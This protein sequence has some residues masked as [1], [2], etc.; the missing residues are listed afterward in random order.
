[1]INMYKARMKLLGQFI[2]V[3]L[4][5]FSFGNCYADEGTLE[6]NSVENLASTTSS[7]SEP[8]AAFNFENVRTA[9]VNKDIVKLSENVTYPFEVCENDYRK[10]LPNKEAFQQYGFNKLFNNNEQFITKF[11]E[12]V[13]TMDL[14]SNTCEICAPDMYYNVSYFDES[15]NAYMGFKY[16]N[17]KGLF[18]FD[19]SECIYR[20]PKVE[21]CGDPELDAYIRMLG[22]ENSNDYIIGEYEN[23]QDH[24]Y[25]YVKLPLGDEI[26]IILDNKKLH[27]KRNMNSFSNMKIYSDD[28]NEYL[29][30]T[31][32]GQSREVCPMDPEGDVCSDAQY[33]HVFKRPKGVPNCGYG[34]IVLADK[35]NDNF[36]PFN[37]LYNSEIRLYDGFY[38][39]L[40]EAYGT[41]SNE[42]QDTKLSI[43]NDPTYNYLNI[44]DFTYQGKQ[45]TYNNKGDLPSYSLKADDKEVLIVLEGNYDQKIT[46]SEFSNSSYV[47][48]N[49]SKAVLFLRDADGNCQRL[50]LPK[51]QSAEQN[52]EQKAE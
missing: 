37:P 16:N 4:G 32:P 46:E 3:A 23:F 48:F 14:E 28:V 36:C 27:L 25:S 9:I 12:H 1:M 17:N 20:L 50:S 35:Y 15:S 19:T 30:V 11:V 38:K 18:E 43:K 47:E 2:I 41:Y 22:Y 26:D 13:K 5:S 40:N 31:A 33:V 39:N 6:E 42:A 45:Y 51:E 21:F 34:D 24:K 8:D 49:Y 44:F 10:V 29:I 52:K 7:E